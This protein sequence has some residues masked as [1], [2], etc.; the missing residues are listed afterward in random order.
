METLMAMSPLKAVVEGMWTGGQ[1]APTPAW[2]AQLSSP[3]RGGRSG[4]I[5]GQ[6]S[7]IPGGRKVTPWIYGQLK[8]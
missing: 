1:P 3:Q 6:S 8:D 2:E 4:R 7:L 5:P